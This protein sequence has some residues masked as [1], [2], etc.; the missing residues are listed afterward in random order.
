MLMAGQRPQVANKKTTTPA[1]VEQPMP[2]PCRACAVRAVSV[3]SAL[4]RAEMAGLAGIVSQCRFANGATIMMEGDPADHLFNIVQGT[5]KI[6]RLLADGRRQVTGFLV[7][8]DFLGLALT[9]A[10]PYSAEAV[11]PVTL[12]RMPRPRFEDL[13]DRFPQLERRMLLNASNELFAAQEQMLLLG[14][15]TA[16]EKVATFLLMMARRAT[17]R[18]R[19]SDE[20]GLAMGRADIGDY[21]GL[22]IETVSRT[23]TQLRRDGFVALHGA[24]RVEILDREGLELAA[25]G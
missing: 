3:C 8:G 4:S 15:K 9:D 16:R 14:R 23:F 12:C 22:T 17:A 21:L 2:E 5:V 18:G 25:E 7:G 6:Y 24:N 20:L 13:I 1:K 10:N 11:G 19:P